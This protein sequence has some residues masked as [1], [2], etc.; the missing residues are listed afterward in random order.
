MLNAETE[1]GLEACLDWA[2][3]QKPKLNIRQTDNEC[4]TQ[5]LMMDNHKPM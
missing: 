3:A 5:T 2:P 4:S 1:N